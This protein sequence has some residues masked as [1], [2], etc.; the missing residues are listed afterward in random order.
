M[1]KDVVITIQGTQTVGN[2]SEEVELFTTGRFYKKDSQYY[3]AYEETEATGFDVCRTTL[4]ISPNQKV[5]MTRFGRSRSQLIVEKGVRH[6][7]SYET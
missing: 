7:C 1:K 6:Q 3:L 4:K 5:T 2:E